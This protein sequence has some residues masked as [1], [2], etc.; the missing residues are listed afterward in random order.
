MKANPED[1]TPPGTTKGGETAVLALVVFLGISRIW[2]GGY[3][4]GIADN[5]WQIPAIR[6]L[7][8][9]EFARDYAFAKPPNL[10]VFFYIFSRLARV[11]R[12]ESLYFAAYAGASVATAVVLYR[13]S[14]RMLR[15]RGAALVAVLLLMTP[16]DVVAGATT[17]DALL[18]PRTV[19]MPFLLLSWLALIGRRRIA[20]GVLLGVAFLVHPLTGLYGGAI[21]VAA[22][23][24]GEQKR[25]RALAQFAAAAAPFAVA[26]L[27]Y[28]RGADAPF[29]AARD[30]WY[31]AMLIRNL[32][33]VVTTRFVL[34]AALLI[35]GLWLGLRLAR[36]EGRGELLM[37][38]TTAT[39]IVFM[40]FGAAYTLGVIAGLPSAG[41]ALL[42]PP[43]L[44]VLQPLRIAGPFGI[45]V[46]VATAGV[47]ESALHRGWPGLLCGVCG[48]AALFFEHWIAGAL[49][50]MGAA[51]CTAN[52]RW[53]GSAAVVLAIAAF[54]TAF[55]FHKPLLILL[56]VT[57]VTS[58][59]VAVVSVRFLVPRSSA[60]LAAALVITGVLPAGW[61]PY[62]ARKVFSG[63]E[64][65]FDR[66]YSAAVETAVSGE[67]A[68]IG[69][70]GWAAAYAAEDEVIIVP[71]WWEGFRVLSG[72]PVFGTY[73]DG[74]LVFFNEALAG[75]W[76]ERMSALSVPLSE[77]KVSRFPKGGL[78]GYALLDEA[79][80][81]E[82]ASRFDATFIVRYEADLPKFREVYAGERV[83]IYEI[84]RMEGPE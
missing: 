74:T 2:I 5:A 18:L 68:L 41:L 84:P 29:L 11:L 76:L 13:L 69:A 23:L 65:K 72:R 58:L 49:L 35:Y 53:R 20:S 59:G 6:S 27:L 30:D 33:H 45:L 47:L 12:L 67:P 46:L 26:A 34:M 32:H 80:I 39:A 8:S 66:R 51:A 40:Y 44:A 55:V 60:A 22:M 63:A 81:L 54:A 19:A 75:E 4:F 48:M 83:H 21:A 71:P 50:V 78:Y 70:A 64:A 77:E 1:L 43:I 57:A 15:R 37:G 25:P 31:R 73:K 56:V 79:R 42:N 82:A 14:E 52:V 36:R 7:A 9:G 28:A 17:W 10:S 38:A 61:V 62:V 16:K 24:T 3:S